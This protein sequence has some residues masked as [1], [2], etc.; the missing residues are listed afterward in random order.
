MRKEWQSYI[1]DLIIPEYWRNV[2]YNNDTL[3]SY[4]CRG[5]QIF[6]DSHS[7]KERV[8]NAK[9]RGFTTLSNTEFEKVLEIGHPITEEIYNK[10]PLRFAVM[11]LEEPDEGHW[12]YLF[13][14]NDFNEIK[15]FVKA[16]DFQC[17]RGLLVSEMGID[18]NDRVNDL[19]DEL[20]FLT[21]AYKLFI[22][23]KG[24]KDV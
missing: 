4:S 16:P 23:G 21:K 2:S 22:K 7:L 12:D 5:Y 20:Y 15:K 13:E 6:I 9:D 11:Y 24:R 3:P 14:S 1:E 17:I 18:I 8:I 10:L 19:P